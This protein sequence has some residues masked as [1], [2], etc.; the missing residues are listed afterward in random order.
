MTIEQNKVIDELNKAVVA[1]HEIDKRSSDELKKFGQ[2][3]SDTAEQV[4]RINDDITALKKQ[5][6][7]RSAPEMPEKSEQEQAK[8]LRS[9]AFD[10]FLRYG[11]KSDAMSPQEVRALSGTSDGDGYFLVAEDLSNQI[12]MRAFN[13]AE[14]RP[15]L[16]RLTT[17]SNRVA[18]GS[19]LKPSVSWGTK[20]IAPTDQASSTGKTHIDVNFLHALLKVDA[21]LLEDSEADIGGVLTMAFSEATAEAEDDAFMVG[22]GVSQ[23]GGILTNATVAASY[24]ASGLAA[25]LTSSTVNG[26]D[27]LMAAY[28]AL[29]KKYRRNATWAC[30][31][32]TEG[33]LRTVKDGEGRYLWQPPLQAGDPAVF[34]GRPV[35]NP[36]GMADIAANSLPIVVGDF[37]R[38]WVVD[39]AGLSV[40]RLNELYA[41]AHQVGFKV[42]KRVGGGTPL[43]EAFRPIKIAVA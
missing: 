3:L 11:M 22:D 23:P 32:T 9:V 10:K 15:F 37:S 24:I 16:S 8:E 13:Q 7:K 27:K 20:A 29:N 6:E 31:S 42:R 4:G 39:R 5:N 41:D 43:P 17:G 25:A 34:N 28:Y 30:N 26:F 1:L 2:Q 38:Y 36:E 12:I 33:V 18:M 21:D 14:V 19:L 40:Q 35:I